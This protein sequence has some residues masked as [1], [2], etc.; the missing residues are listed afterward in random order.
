[1]H[2][3]P[4]SVWAPSHHLCSSP[5]HPHLLLQLVVLAIVLLLL[6]ACCWAAGTVEEKGGRQAQG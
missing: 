3:L 4:V 6:L 5:T 1:M 2:A